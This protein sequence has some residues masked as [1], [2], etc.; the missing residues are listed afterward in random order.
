MDE[1][2]LEKNK[3]DI[4]LKTIVKPLKMHF[5]RFFVGFDEFMQMQYNLNYK[6]VEKTKFKKGEFYDTT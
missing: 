2:S 1:K 6:K 4:K 5:K 3:V